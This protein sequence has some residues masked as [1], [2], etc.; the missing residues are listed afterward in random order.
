M[1]KTLTIKQITEEVSEHLNDV[2]SCF[3]KVKF[4]DGD[5]EIYLVYLR[6]DDLKDL[7]YIMLQLRKE[8]LIAFTE[9]LEQKG[10]VNRNFFVTGGELF[11]S[12]QLDCVNLTIE[13][14]EGIF[15]FDTAKDSEY[16]I[17]DMLVELNSQD[18]RLQFK[19]LSFAVSDVEVADTKLS[20]FARKIVNDEISS[21]KFAEFDKIGERVV[22][23]NN[24]YEQVKET[25]AEGSTVMDLTMNNGKVGTLNV[26]I[27]KYKFNKNS[28][29]LKWADAPVTELQHMGK[30]WFSVIINKK[31]IQYTKYLEKDFSKL[32][33]KEYFIMD[34]V[35]REK[36]RS[37]RKGV[38]VA[39]M[40]ILDAY[41]EQ[42]LSTGSR[43]DRRSS[44]ST[45]TDKNVRVTL[46]RDKDETTTGLYKL[47]KSNKS[48]CGLIDLYI[49]AS[50]A[51]KEELK[52]ELEDMLKP[53][54]E[55]VIDS[56]YAFYVLYELVE[57][58]GLVGDFAF[59]LG[60]VGQHLSGVRKELFEYEML[61]ARY[62]YHAMS[63]DWGM[64][65]SQDTFVYE[66]Y[67]GARVLIER[68]G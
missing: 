22:F 15:L 56:E 61:C 68:R 21:A 3:I 24:K 65:S 36:L 43:T 60:A 8:N 41:G 67:L 50:S 27:P 1:S 9:F 42:P 17:W 40:L 2:T 23:Y 26:L 19:D 51:D 32:F 13:G 16:S 45:R 25:N 58:L 4:V 5:K 7:R 62:R 14:S 66:S 39:E 55:D 31:N 59:K 64:L 49:K 63:Y 37:M 57:M 52:T 46:I 6:N 47:I 35:T 28:L 38:E 12:K 11:L 29:Y 30:D 34:F 33:C 48:L 44:Q 18:A 20:L 10:I 54:L 53:V